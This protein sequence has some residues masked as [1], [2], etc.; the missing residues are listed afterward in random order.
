MNSLKVPDG[1]LLLAGSSDQDL[2]VP[3]QAFVVSLS[4]DVVEQ[5]IRSA[6]MGDDLELELGKRPVCFHTSTAYSGN[7]G[8]QLFV[9]PWQVTWAISV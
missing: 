7:T 1:G 5:M 4:D 8:A 6:R 3:P 2:G 9:G